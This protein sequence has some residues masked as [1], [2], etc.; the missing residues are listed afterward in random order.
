[1]GSP[2]LNADF[3]HYLS[4]LARVAGLSVCRDGIPF[5]GRLIEIDGSGLCT[6]DHRTVVSIPPA[7]C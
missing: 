3:R 2:Q 5:A 4:A 1:M 6:I 7:A